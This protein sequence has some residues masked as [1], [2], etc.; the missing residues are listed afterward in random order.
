MK[1]LG[2]VLGLLC[3][4]AYIAFQPLL[5]LHMELGGVET[6]VAASSGCHCC[7]DTCA[8]ETQTGGCRLVAKTK[9]LSVSIK[10]AACHTGD[11]KSEITMPALR[12]LLV[13]ESQVF[14]CEVDWSLCDY[15]SLAD[16]LLGQDR[17]VLER[18]PRYS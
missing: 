6:T 4:G 1:K 5:V 3:V 7:G 12:W 16:R 8:C 18:P 2:L 14:S 13:P 15:I 17:F 11:Q 9:T 10:G